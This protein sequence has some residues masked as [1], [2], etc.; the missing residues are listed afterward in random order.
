MLAAHE[1]IQAVDVSVLDLLYLSVTLDSV[2][3]CLGHGFV[4]WLEAG[5]FVHV[6]PYSDVA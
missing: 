1:A 3:I 4:G 5:W 6:D 2:I